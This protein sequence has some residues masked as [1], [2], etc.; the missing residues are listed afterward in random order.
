MEI[1]TAAINCLQYSVR[2]AASTPTTFAPSAFPSI[3]DAIAAANSRAGLSASLGLQCGRCGAMSGLFR[4]AESAVCVV[5]YR[6]LLD[7]LRLDGLEPVEFD[8]ESTD[9][10]KTKEALNNRM[11]LSD[12]L[13]LKL[14][15]PPENKETPGSIYSTGMD[16]SSQNTNQIEGTPAFANW[17]AD[18]QSASSES[19]F[20]DSKQF[21]LFK[22]ALTDKT[23]NFP[24]PGTAINPVVPSGNG[25]DLRNSKLDDSKD[26]ASASGRLV[27]DGSDSGIFPETSVAELTE[28]PISKN[29]VQSNQLPV[30]VG[31]TASI[32][33]EHSSEA[34]PVGLWPVDNVK[35]LNNTKMLKETNNSFDVWQDFTTSGQAQGTPSNQVGDV[36]KVSHVTN[37]ETDD[38]SWFKGDVREG[39]NTDLVNKSNIT[40]DDLQ[41]F[42]GSDLAQRSSSNVGGE[43]MNL[44]FGKHEG[45]DTMQSWMDDSNKIATNTVTTNIEDNSFDIWQDFTMSC[46]QKESFS[47]FGKETTSASS[48]PAKETDPLDMWLTS[49][50]QESN[51]NK[52]VNRINDSSC[53]W[54]DFANFGQMQS[55]EISA[56]GGVIDP[57]GAEPLDLWASSNANKLKNHEQINEDSDPFDDWQD[58]K[59]SHPLD[60]SLQV[61]S[62][63]S[64]DNPTALK[65]D[66]LQGLEFGGF[67]PSV[68]SQS[69]SDNRENT[70]E[71]NTVPSDE[72]LER[73]IGMQQMSDADSLSAIWPTT[74]RGTTSVFEQKSANANVKRLL[75]RMHDLS[76]ML[77]DDMP[78]P[79][80]TVCHSKS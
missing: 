52:D 9:S 73:T 51:S 61:S 12:L 19:V 22:S 8:N 14:T 3:A 42:A 15:F 53:G 72:H 20:K 63:A 46:H 56:S 49:N 16:S 23:S 30:R 21:D 2:E 38:D 7:S 54:Q 37:K 41:G 5:A 76:F 74:S 78:I 17:N 40:L 4:G 70:N 62:N 55:M 75:S 27:K 33:S 18:F 64:L 29:S 57:S 34:S 65:L 67:A 60:T 58:F 26:L 1:P 59:N 45:T 48:G 13:D 36:L 10:S 43:T 79:D 31:E 39:R 80:K 25:T 11:I 6:W 44:S 71:E 28:S 35:E 69:Q 32:S 50:A 77:K 24:Y 66:A 68:P 47:I